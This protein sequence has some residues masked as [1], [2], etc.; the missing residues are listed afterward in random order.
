MFQFHYSECIARD[1]GTHDHYCSLVETDVGGRGGFSVTYG[2]NNRSVPTELAYFD[3]TKCL[4]FDIM[5]TLFEGV[6]PHLLKQLLKYIVDEGKFLTVEQLNSSLSV[7]CTGYS[8]KDT[9]P[10][11]IYRDGGSGSDFHFKQ[12]GF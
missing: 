2:V 7:L 11:R 4:P 6:A 8:E 9:A 5:H 1:K 10:A 12:K 3:I